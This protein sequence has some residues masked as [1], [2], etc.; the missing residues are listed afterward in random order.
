MSQLRIHIEIPLGRMVNKWCIFKRPLEVK[1]DNIY[2][3]IRS[4]M[5]LHNLCTDKNEYINVIP[6]DH[7]VY[8]LRYVEYIDADPFSYVYGTKKIQSAHQGIT[9]EA[10]R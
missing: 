1:L 4:A 5:R 6:V 2:M 3:I 9:R 10:I 8:V 7:E